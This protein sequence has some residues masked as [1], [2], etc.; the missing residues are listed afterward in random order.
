MFRWFHG[1]I[2]GCVMAL[3]VLILPGP[4]V[5][6]EVEFTVEGH[7]QPF[8][9]TYCVAC[10]GGEEPAGEFS[11]DRSE[12]FEQGADHFEA[13]ETVVE[14]LRAD[15]MPPEDE[16]QPEP[17]ERKQIVSLIGEKFLAIDCETAQNSGPAT[18]RR[19]NRAEYANTIRD[20]LGIEYEGADDFPS[21]DVGYGFDN[22]GDVLSISP[23]L[24]ERYLAAAEEI[25]AQAIVADDPRRSRIVRFEAEDLPREVPAGASLD[26]LFYFYSGGEVFTE[27]EIGHAGD[28]RLRA[29]AF[30][31][32][33]GEEPVK[34]AFSVGEERV[35]VVDVA[36]TSAKPEVY[37]AVV[38]LPAGKVRLA[39]VFANDFY[40]ESA[41]EGEPRDRNMAI[42]YVELEGPLNVEPM[43]LPESHRRIMICEPTPE[44]R[45]KCV[46]EIIRNFAE[47]AYR[48][49]LSGIEVSRLANLVDYA[50]QEG[51]SFERGIQ[52]VVQAV[53]ASPHF[54]FRTE[55]PDKRVDDGRVTNDYQLATRLSYFLWSSMPDDTLF[56][57][58]EEDELHNPDVL[59]EQVLRMLADPRSVA[60]VENFAAQWLQIR[61]L[62]LVDPDQNR[63][64]GFDDDLRAAMRRETELFFESLIREDRSVLEMIDADFTFL[65]ERL[66]K[67]YGINGVEGDA[68]RRVELADRTRGGVLTQASVL[69]VTSNPTRTSPVK[70]GKWVMEQ[71]LAVTPPEA[72]PNVPQLEDAGRKLEGTLRQKMEQHRSDPSCAI[73]HAQM[74][75]LGFGLENFDAVGAW[76]TKDEGLPIDASGELPS[77][78]TFAGPAELKQILLERGD[79]FRR[80]IAE[81]LLV[82]AI[83]RGLTHND[84]CVV[85]EIV[86]ALREGDD[87]FSQLVLAIV[88]CD[89]FNPGQST[90]A[91]R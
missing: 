17:D 22:I 56:E 44:T 14:Y 13:W 70:R 12:L 87:R 60:L 45:T 77:G 36:A 20:L 76:R 53:L 10:H 47:R 35:H 90:G 64:P 42:D 75:P 51:A 7:L 63:F 21:D 31:E 58:A 28:Y 89:A 23:I 61:N 48:R 49:P 39:W 3:L 88:R 29:R 25:A 40:D 74:D 15:M 5:A 46:R 26:S 66:A 67:H 59:E 16:A 82:Y 72:P 27:V 69:T 55:L 80:C 19:L 62:D 50:T 34:L 11:L 68:F 85:D 52:L 43:P 9:S 84:E 41:P 37:G 30:G 86:T 78:A 33:A 18:L 83:G 32:Q 79:D 73:C 65:N 24:M 81:K 91:E 8:L 54:L 6:D 57:L 1:F 38:E 2:A 71:L 4:L